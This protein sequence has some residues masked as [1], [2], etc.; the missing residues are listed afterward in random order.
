VSFTYQYNDANQRTRNTE[1]NGDYW[2]YQY[3]TLGQVSSGKKYTSGGTPIAGRQFEYDFDDIANRDYTVADGTTTDYTANLLNQ[4]TTRVTGGTTETFQHDEDGNLQS[5]SLW[6]Y[7]W[8][9]ENRLVKLESQASVPDASKRKLQFEYDYR[10]RRIAKKVYIWSGGGY[11]PTPS[12]S[13]KSVYDDWNLLAELDANNNVVRSYIWGLD[14][15]VSEQGAG[16]V[17]GLL[18][19]TDHSSPVTRHF[20]AFDGNGNVMALV[21]A[22]DGTVS[23]QYEYSPFGETLSA[24]GSAA[25]ANPFRFS[26]KYVDSESGF[27]Y[28][29]Y[30]YYNPSTGRFL[31]MDPIIDP[32]SN[33]YSFSLN[34]A[35]SFIDILGLLTCPITEESISFRQ[36]Q[37]D[38][39]A[40]GIVLA[41]NE[42][43]PSFPYHITECAKGKSR[44]D[45]FNP[46]CY[47]IIRYAGNINKTKESYVGIGRNAVTVGQH[48]EL[49]VKNAERN[50]SKVEDKHHEFVNKCLCDDCFTAWTKALDETYKYYKVQTLYDDYT[51]DIN[52]Y[53]ISLK[54]KVMQKRNKISIS[55]KY[56]S[57]KMVVAWQHKESVC[58][59][60]K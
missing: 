24:T 21:N 11:S 47:A 54:L 49:H 53:E 23:A 2:S 48:E 55:L 36:L 50:Y 12:V 52:H 59:E 7:T 35:I 18:L 51:L 15:S 20:V 32:D 39:D 45:N 10:S 46:S 41:N 1:A 16:G 8:D 14:L 9:G 19:F 25:A 60:C 5:D 3:D 58:R 30:R 44:A 13:L 56:L 40:I 26:T 33:L 42:V 37:R 17:G 43:N 29:G 34:N 27:L 22:V 31:N 28:Y 38:P 4:Y 6:V 57:Q